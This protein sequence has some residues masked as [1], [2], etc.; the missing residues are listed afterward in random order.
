[1]RYP[2]VDVNKCMLIDGDLDRWVGALWIHRRDVGAQ[3]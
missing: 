3:S 1:M 2:Y